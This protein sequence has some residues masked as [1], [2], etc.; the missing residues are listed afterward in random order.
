MTSGDEHPLDA[1]HRVSD[2]A[3]QRRVSPGFVVFLCSLVL[4]G[5]VVLWRLGR[6]VSYYGLPRPH[7]VVAPETIDLGPLRTGTSTSITV[8]LANHGNALLRLEKIESPCSECIRVVRMPATTIA[9]HSATDLSA[10]FQAPLTAGKL[11][12]TL[13]IQSNDPTAPTTVVRVLADVRAEDD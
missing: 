6:I 12:R 11:M 8:R 4:F 2:S 9:P 7:L 13:R 5:G 3:F 1:Q 10:L